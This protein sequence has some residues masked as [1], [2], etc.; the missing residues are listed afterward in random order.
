M[1]IPNAFRVIDLW[2]TSE[3]DSEILVSLSTND[4]VNTVFKTARSIVVQTQNIGTRLHNS[5]I[6]VPGQS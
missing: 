2:P 4:L 5:L 6:T 3:Y 1:R